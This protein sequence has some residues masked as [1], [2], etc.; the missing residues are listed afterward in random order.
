MKTE[1]NKTVVRRNFEEAWN[2]QNLAVV[3]ELFAEDYIGHF[4]VHPQPVSGIEALRQFMSGYFVAFPDARFT[5]ENMFA[6]GDRVAAR[7]TVRGTHQGNLGAVPP[8]GRQI[9]VTGVWILRLAGGKIAEQW[10]VFDSLGLMQ[11]LGVVP[12]PGQQ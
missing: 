11:Q 2:E 12:T 4:A 10:G 3:D 8:T 9:T 1:E 7:W 5:I 6:E